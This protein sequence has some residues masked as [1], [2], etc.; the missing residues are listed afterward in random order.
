MN[1]I[2]EINSYETICIIKPDLNEDN[3]AKVIENY[4]LMLANQGAKNII[5]QNR[6]RRHLK[7]MMKKF[8]DGIYI[9]MNYEANGEVISTLEKN[10]KIDEQILRFMTVKNSIDEQSKIS[11]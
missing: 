3:L 1:G 7:Y 4:Q 11:V 9:Q 2:K 6:G 5:T 8:K 10:M